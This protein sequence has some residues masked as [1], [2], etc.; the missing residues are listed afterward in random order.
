MLHPARS[1]RPVEPAFAT[2]VRIER[3]GVAPIKRCAFANP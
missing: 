2:L 3:S 1:D